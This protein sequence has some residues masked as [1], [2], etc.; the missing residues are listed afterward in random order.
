VATEQYK[1]DAE[2]PLGKCA[3]LHLRTMTPLFS[4]RL[5]ARDLIEEPVLSEVCVTLVDA[6]ALSDRQFA[7][8]VKESLWA[9]SDGQTPVSGNDT[10]LS[11]STF[12]DSGPQCIGVTAFTA[13]ATQ[14]ALGLDSVSKLPPDAA[15]T[16]DGYLVLHGIVSPAHPSGDSASVSHLFLSLDETETI[17]STSSNWVKGAFTAGISG[18][19]TVP[20]TSTR[21][22]LSAVAP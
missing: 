13:N 2:E 1:H 8:E 4:M 12:Y 19:V 21:L 6:G 9:V 5:V 15:V 18:L 22:P 14:A 11:A 10:W 16:V 17:S 7:Q 20:N 3:A